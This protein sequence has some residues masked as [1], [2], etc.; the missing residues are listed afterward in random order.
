MQEAIERLRREFPDRP[1]IF[2]PEQN[3]L[4]VIIEL[5][6]LDQRGE[7]IA[8]ITRSAPHVHHKTVEVYYV[9]EGILC[10]YTDGRP[11]LLF[12]GDRFLVIPHV[13]HWAT[14]NATR[15]R[16]VTYPPWS[17]EDHILVE[18]PL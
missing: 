15:V 6:T 10:L 17:A 9:Q 2:L 3:P 8:L 13:T 5:V 16:I 11:H 1:L 18:S 12:P 4:E 7:A 14:G